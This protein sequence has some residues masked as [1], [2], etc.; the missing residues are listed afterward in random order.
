MHG[1]RR[2]EVQKRRGEIPNGRSGHSPL[3]RPISGK[4]LARTTNH[5]HF[6]ITWPVLG[7]LSYFGC[8]RGPAGGYV[9]R[10]VV[11]QHSLPHLRSPPLDAF[12]SSSSLPRCWSRTMPIAKGKTVSVRF[13][14]FS[15]P[16]LLLIFGL[17]NTQRGKKISEAYPRL[18]T[19][20]TTCARE[21]WETHRLLQKT[22]PPQ[23]I[24]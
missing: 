12:V 16:S 3:R 1:G 10:F 19:G 2:N 18:E 14:I 4:V 5:P 6:P 24:D 21:K 20:D 13:D 15:V 9:T 23:H 11:V 22:S 8:S 17:V 7:M